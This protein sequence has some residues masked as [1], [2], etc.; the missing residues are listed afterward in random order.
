M[1]GSILFVIM[2]LQV[3]F[4]GKL[5]VELFSFNYVFKGVLT[6]NCSYFV[7]YTSTELVLDE[8][9]LLTVISMYHRTYM[10]LKDISVSL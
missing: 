6:E 5:F 10:Q 9:T 1:N 3:K 7:L 2:G 4:A 8:P